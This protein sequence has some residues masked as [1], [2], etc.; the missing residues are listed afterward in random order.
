ME[1]LTQ[2]VFPLAAAGFSMVYLLAG[3]G[4]FGAIAIFFIAKMIGK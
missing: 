4:V 2:T 3:G 1:I